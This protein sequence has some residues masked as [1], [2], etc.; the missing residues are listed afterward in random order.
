MPHLARAKT[1][2]LWLA[3]R[4]VTTL[5]AT[6]SRSTVEARPPTTLL[7]GFLG[8]GKTTALT[9]LLTN[10]E[11]LRIAVL[12]ND[13][14]SVNV[15]AM[16]VRRTTIDADGVEMVQLENGCVCCGPGSGDLAPAVRTLLERTEPAF[17][18][19]VVELS[20]V[21]DPINVQN[22]LG[23]GG[24]SVERKVALVDANSFPAQYGSVQ[25]ARE[26]ED[27]A[28]ADVIEMDPCA[29]DR[30]VVELLLQQVETA[31]VILVNKCDLATDDELR[32][33]LAACRVLNERA[34]IVS[35][36]FGDAALSDVLPRKAAAPATEPGPEDVSATFELML[37]GI[38]CGGCGSALEKA[39]SDVDGVAEV[40]AK[41]F[42]D[43]GA[44]PNAV[45][46]KGAC[47]EG[48]LREVRVL[49]CREPP[50]WWCAPSLTVVHPLPLTS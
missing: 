40:S 35:T 34:S 22:N 42:K 7:G 1:L 27:L 48:A 36:T 37:N 9:H 11:G 29:V 2:C 49:C 23:L 44:H 41:S 32:T 19:V 31:D 3:A 43:T 20:G 15:D 50:P 45:V 10:R 12:V 13:V 28:G 24:V 14:A 4:G 8:A 30:R 6:L 17:D 46:V 25:T 33:T 21:A 47:T 18:H 5:S 39:L 38:N 26:R 16:V